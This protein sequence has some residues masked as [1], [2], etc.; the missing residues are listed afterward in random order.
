MSG[1]ALSSLNIQEGQEIGLTLI[2][3]IF[4]NA[5]FV[6]AGHLLTTVKSTQWVGNVVLDRVLNTLHNWK[7]HTARSSVETTSYFVAI[8]FGYVATGNMLETGFVAS[9]TGVVVCSVTETFNERDGGRYL[10]VIGG[11]DGWE[12]KHVLLVLGTVWSCAILLVG[13]LTVTRNPVIS[14]LGALTVVTAIYYALDLMSSTLAADEYPPSKRPDQVPESQWSSGVLFHPPSKKYWRIRG[15]WYDLNA[16]LDIHPGGRKVLELSR[17]RFED[18]TYVFE[19]HHHD[20]KRARAVLRK[21]KVVDVQELASIEEG[22]AWQKAQRLET[23]AVDREAVPTRLLGDDSFYSVFALVLASTLKQSVISTGS[24]P[25]AAL[26]F[27]GASSQR[28]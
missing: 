11:G 3:W 22:L 21:Y 4:T 12:K 25:R 28:G 8:L 7:V 18:A 16:F 13:L 15:E 19:A 24:P 14:I 27:S 5:L 9:F 10:K 1:G 20:Y 23:V 6:S 17:D 26:P 2:T